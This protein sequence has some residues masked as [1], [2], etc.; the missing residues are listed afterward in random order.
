MLEE[1]GRKAAGDVRRRRAEAER[2]FA[3]IP[4]A[5]RSSLEI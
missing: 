2:G 4:E 5:N 1:R 3:E